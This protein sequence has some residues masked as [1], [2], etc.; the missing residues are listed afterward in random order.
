[1]ISNNEINNKVP[2]SSTIPESIGNLIDLEEL[3]V[4]LFDYLIFLFYFLLI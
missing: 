2:D 1:M 4:K 3:Y